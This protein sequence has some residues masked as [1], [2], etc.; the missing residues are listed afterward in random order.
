M[1]DKRMPSTPPRFRARLSWIAGL[2]AAGFSLHCSPVAV[3]Q[4]A[5]SLM[6]DKTSF[7]SLEPMQATVSISNRSGA[8]VIMSGPNQA[9]WITFNITDSAG[10]SLTPIAAAP[11]QPFVFKAGSTVAKK[12]LISDSYSFSDVGSY[13]VSATVYHPPTQQFYASNR[14][15]F[16]VT[17]AKPF[18]EQPV[19]VPEGYANAGRIHRYALIKFT[20]L[21]KAFLYLRLIDDRSNLNLMTYQLG[22][23]AVSLDPQVQLDPE[24][25]LHVMFLAAPKIFAHAVVAPDG[26]LKLREYFKE[27]ESNRP[28][29]VVSAEG[30]VQVQGGQTFDPFAPPPP[31]PKSRSI[32]EKPPG[33]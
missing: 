12:I 21:E 4:F 7:L 19:G 5:T 2:M 18:W 16:T 26:K 24:N 10:R 29:L 25:K 30:S 8:D 28:A 11:E 13:A 15:R 3:A 17:D 22:P 14:V 9:N 6:L 1:F 31:K 27:G 23:L 32:S 33:L 20:D